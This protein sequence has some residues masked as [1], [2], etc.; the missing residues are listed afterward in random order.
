MGQ[1]PN[2]KEMQRVLYRQ[3]TSHAMPAKQ[4][5]T[6]EEQ[7]KVMRSAAAGQSWVLVLDGLCCN[8]IE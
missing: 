3:L 6:A 5:A 1:E 2:I 4:D 8:A 7:L